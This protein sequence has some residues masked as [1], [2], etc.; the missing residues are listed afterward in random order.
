MRSRRPAIL[1][2]KYA[3]G[4]ASSM[5]VTVTAEAM[6]SVRR[7]IVGYGSCAIARKLSRFH[8]WI[9]W[10]VNESVVQKL[11]IR[12]ATSAAT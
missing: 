11:W 5:H 9:T 1:T 3:Y 8:E 6:N 7:M 4:N 10:P 12:S 2:R